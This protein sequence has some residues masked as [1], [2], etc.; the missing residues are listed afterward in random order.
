MTRAAA[1]LVLLL[2]SLPSLAIPPPERI[3]ALRHGVNISG[4]FRYPAS[5]EPAVLRAWLSDNA[6]AGLKEAG[7]TFVRLAVDPSL[8][9]TPS[10]RHLF[11]DQ[12]R[13]L[14]RHGLAVVISP[15]PVGWSIDTNPGDRARF[16][17]FWKDLAPALRDMDPTLTFPE[18]LNEPVFHDNPAAWW[19]LQHSLLATIRA[20][21]PVHTII[22]TGQDWGSISGLLALTPSPDSQNRDSNVSYSFHF[23]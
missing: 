1:L 23:C 3:A 8:L 20:V 7:F 4:W 5:R 19:G 2:W 6:M 16:V 17:T 11:L 12:V 21:L 22:L 9:E 15:H 18:I 14:Q 10:M 13:R